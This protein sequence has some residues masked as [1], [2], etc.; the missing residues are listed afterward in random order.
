MC[1]VIVRAN[2]RLFSLLAETKSLVFPLNKQRVS[3]KQQPA[4][5]I[6]LLNVH[7]ATVGSR[8]I[9]FY[10]PLV[11]KVLDLI[12]FTFH[13]S[14]F[15]VFLLELTRPPSVLCMY[16]HVFTSNVETVIVKMLILHKCELLIHL[17]CRASTDTH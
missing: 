17:N 7:Q 16:S 3:N 14:L 6:R 11:C 4:C 1:C 15:L 8:Q 5:F 12:E 10:P 2:K 9:P 13:A